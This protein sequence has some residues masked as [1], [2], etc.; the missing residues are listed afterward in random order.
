MKRLITMFLS[1]MVL[2]VSAAF[3]QYV[4]KGV[5]VDASGE[6]VIGAAVLQKGT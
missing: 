5:V 2:S 4:A 6:P 3:A 1:I